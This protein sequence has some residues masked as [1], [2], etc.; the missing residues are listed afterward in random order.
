M[1]N[2]CSIHIECRVIKRALGS[3]I[4]FVVPIMWL[5]IETLS[6]NEAVWEA[7]KVRGESVSHSLADLPKD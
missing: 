4:Y 6:V 7:A 3:R 5:L 2:L 1:Q